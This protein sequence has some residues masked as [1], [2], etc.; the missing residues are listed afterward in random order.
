M[1]AFGM[2]SRPCEQTTAN[3]GMA[4]GTLAEN[5]VFP[6]Q[7]TEAMSHTHATRAFVLT[8]A[9][10]NPLD[11][12]SAH[13]PMGSRHPDYPWLVA[14]S[15]VVLK[16]LDAVRYHVA[17]HY[18]RAPRKPKPDRVDPVPRETIPSLLYSHGMDPDLA[19]AAACG[20]AGLV[21]WVA[22]ELW[23]ALTW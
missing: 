4:P 13:I 15:Q 22:L 5:D 20:I 6:K 3:I 19:F 16:R 14:A 8:V 23:F 18:V 10:G 12:L 11:A 1:I 9:T 17:V 7:L 21:T 2:Q